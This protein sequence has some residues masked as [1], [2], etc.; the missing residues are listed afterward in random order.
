M[1]RQILGYLAPLSFLCLVTAVPLTAGETGPLL[2]QNCPTCPQPQYQYSTPS[3]EYYSPSPSSGDSYIEPTP[4]DMT[5]SDSNQSVPPPPSDSPESSQ[6][7]SNLNQPELNMQA[8]DLAT[9]TFNPSVGSVASTAATSP[10]ATA[11]NMIGDLFGGSVSGTVPLVVDRLFA[12]TSDPILGPAIDPMSPLALTAASM[13]IDPHPDLL[14]SRTPGGA[15]LPMVPTVPMFPTEFTTVDSQADIV[16]AN[17]GIVG[18]VV[19]IVNNASVEAE[20]AA[21][22]DSIHGHGTTTF[23]GSESNVVVDSHIAAIEGEYTPTWVYDY[24]IMSEIAGISNPGGLPGGNVGRQKLTENASPLPRDRVYVNYSYFHNTPLTNAGVHVNRVTPGFEKTF[25]GGDMSIEVRAP[26]ATT[27]DSDLLSGTLGDSKSTEFGNMTVYLKALLWD[28]G[29][30][31]VSAGVGF[32]LPTADDATYGDVFKVENESVHVLPFIGALFLPTERMFVQGFLQADIDPTGN[33]FSYAEFNPNGPRSP[34][35]TI[36]R[37]NDADMIFFDI[38]F[39][40]WIYQAPLCGGCECGGCPGAPCGHRHGWIQGIAPT[41]E[42]HYNGTIESADT[43]LV[44]RGPSAFTVGN[45]SQGDIDLWNLVLG[46]NFDLQ[47]N[48]SL[49]LAYATPLDSD[50]EE[51]FD[52]EFRVMFNWYF[53][54]SDRFISPPTF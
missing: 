24:T 44:Q 8:P 30:E 33:P 34:M 4:M 3:N 1:T 19:P 13:A 42:L 35:R 20:A 48:A 11:P 10:Q 12:T 52:S 14:I 32:T 25:F 50:G 49:T 18:A 5:P 47:S 17:P 28:A 41:V 9:P 21:L 36:G 31:A 54:G 53:G 45:G 15:A 7:Q 22:G 51:Q 39:G 29:F 37:P 46:V 23:I 16:M 26:F 27:L 38:G 40:Y 2:A 43:V 6:Q